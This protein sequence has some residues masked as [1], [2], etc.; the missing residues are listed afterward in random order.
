MAEAYR[1]VKDDRFAEAI[2]TLERL[3]PLM[4]AVLGPEAEELIE[5][6][7][8]I[9]SY[10]CGL[11][12]PGNAY[13]VTLRA[14]TICEKHYGEEGMESCQLRVALGELIFPVLILFCFSPTRIHVSR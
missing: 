14:L 10:H 8:D 12:Q 9:G 3:L 13:T 5:P 2:A 4:E 11:G 1:F 6:L 7:K